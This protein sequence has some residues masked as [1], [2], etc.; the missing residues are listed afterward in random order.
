MALT[1]TQAGLDKAVQADLASVSFKITHVALGA[2]GYIPNKE[3]SALQNEIAGTRVALSGGEN[4]APN[5][6]HLT[7]LFDQNTT[8]TAREIG[9][10]LEDGTLFAVDSHPSDVLV[11]KKPS[12]KSIEAFDLILDAVPP[13]SIT[14]N[15]A[16]DLS[17]Y[18]AGSFA[19]M[20]TAQIHNMR[21]T[22]INLAKVPVV[23]AESGTGELA[24]IGD[25]TGSI[26]GLDFAESDNVFTL[27]LTQPETAVVF[28]NVVSIYTAVAQVTL[29]IK[30]GTGA[31]QVTWPDNVKWTNDRAPTLSYIAGYSDIVTLLYNKNTGNWYGFSNGGWFSA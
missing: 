25:V 27:T 19:V 9:F 23:A 29:L 1:V 15:T 8:I 11:Y 20:A 31:N 5:Q 26:V 24:T 6:I 22:L 7:A 18:Y 10:Y 13:G 14:V 4:V 16:G 28:Q 3:M 17:L 2:N 12:T 30:Q 21:R